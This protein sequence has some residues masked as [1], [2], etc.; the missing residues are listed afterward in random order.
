[1]FSFDEKTQMRPL[2]RTQP[3]LPM[4]SGRPGTLTH[5]NKRH[6]TTDLFAALNDAT[7]EVCFDT[8]KSHT[9]KDVL[10]FFELT[11]LHTPK[12][13]EIHVVLDNLAWP[14]ALGLVALV[15]SVP[16]DNV[17]VGPCRIEVL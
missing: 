8:K 1:M 2:D 15:L 4:K 9:S 5:E 7:D 17:R 10:S 11:D 13:L 16:S 14:A 3:T 6:G 12:D